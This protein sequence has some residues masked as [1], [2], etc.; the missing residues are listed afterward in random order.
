MKYEW[1]AAVCV[2]LVKLATDQNVHI[3][4]VLLKI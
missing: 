2:V 1:D 3:K 4:L